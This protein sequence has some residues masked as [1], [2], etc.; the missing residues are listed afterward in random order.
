MVASTPK[1]RRFRVRWG[2]VGYWAAAIATIA[3]V[4]FPFYW[5]INTS[6]KPQAILHA[7]PAHWWPG[8]HPHWG[9]YLDVFRLHPFARYLL[10]SLVVSV[11][12]TLLALLFAAFAGYALGRLHFRGKAPTLF[13]VLAVSMFPPIAIISPLYIMFYQAGLLSSYPG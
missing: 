9:N 6:L 7:V 13:V 11:M 12:T 1:R 4:L 10:D 3:F 8:S 2:K 5:Q